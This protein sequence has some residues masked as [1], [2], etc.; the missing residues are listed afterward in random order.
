LE[1]S[2]PIGLKHTRVRRCLT[3]SLLDELRR[4][5]WI[6][7]HLLRQRET[8]L[9]EFRDLLRG[10]LR[11]RASYSGHQ[12]LKKAHDGGKACKLRSLG[13]ALNRCRDESRPDCGVA[14]VE[15]ERRKL[16]LN[17]VDLVHEVVLLWQTVANPPQF[18]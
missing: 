17:L 14:G 16:R 13:Q 18:V 11:I 12:F 1:I 7:D 8:A 4:P 5:P 6:V 3:P 15:S 2:N 9:V 10:I